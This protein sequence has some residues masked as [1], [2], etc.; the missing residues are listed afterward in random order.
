MMR[1]FKLPLIV[2]GAALVLAVIVGLAAVTWL[3]G[4]SLSNRQKEQRAQQLGSATAMIVC[5]V[6]APF[7]FVSA[8][9]FGKERRKAQKKTSRR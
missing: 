9:K 3:D 2:T 7:W 5:V 6:I 8:A 4:A 1:H